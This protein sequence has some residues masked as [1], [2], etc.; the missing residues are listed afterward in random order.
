MLMVESSRQM[1]PPEGHFRSLQITDHNYR[2]NNR[3]SMPKSYCQNRGRILLIRI[4]SGKRFVLVVEFKSS[5]IHS[6]KRMALKACFSR[7][8][9][10]IH[11]LIQRR[12]PFLELVIAAALETCSHSFGEEFDQ[13]DF[14]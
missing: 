12:I 3:I 9:L 8:L 2:G 4:E 6:T 14:L 7:S 5:E 13:V 1:C 10:R 11:H